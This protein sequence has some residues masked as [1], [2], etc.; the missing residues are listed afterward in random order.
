[1]FIFNLW[2][3]LV[4]LL[5]VLA[6][7]GVHEAAPQV[8]QGTMGNF[9]VGVITF[10]FGGIAEALGMRGRIFFLPVWLFGLIIIGFQ[11]FEWWGI[12]GILAGLLLGVGGVVVLLMLAKRAE[13]KKWECLQK[14]SFSEEAKFAD[15]PAAYWTIVRKYLFLPASIDYSPAIYAHN[16]GVLRHVLSRSDL[17]LN[18]PETGILKDFSSALTVLEAAPEPQA[19]AGES[20]KAISQLI[21]SKASA[22]R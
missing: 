18:E 2:A 13:V 17:G 9:I 3:L 11:L 6:S 4:G 22:K 1:M 16:Q 10:V 21:A 14:E 19:P 15:K 5:V 8:M 20:I 12:W 7:L